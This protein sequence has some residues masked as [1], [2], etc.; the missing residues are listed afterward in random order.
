V[1]LPGTAPV[2]SYE[3]DSVSMG[4]GD[5]WSTTGD[6][7]AWVD[8]LRAGRLLTEASTRLMFAEQAAT[9]GDPQARG[10]GYGWFVGSVAGEPWLHH[11]GDNDGFKAFVAWLPRSDRRI[12]I[13][14]NQD[15]T[16]PTQVYDL[17]AASDTA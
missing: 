1:R 5:V 15:D 7:L 4:A 6:L 3:L 11:S 17:I 13:L 10:Y 8:G 9:G 12:V 16:D 14:S 2:A